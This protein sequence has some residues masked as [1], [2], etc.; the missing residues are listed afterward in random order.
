MLLQ[1]FVNSAKLHTRFH[2]LPSVPMHLSTAEQCRI[3]DRSTI[4]ARHLFADRG[5][6]YA[7]QQ[8][9]MSQA[10][11]ASDTVIFAS[12]QSHMTSSLVLWALAIISP[13]HAHQCCCISACPPLPTNALQISWVKTQL[14]LSK[15]S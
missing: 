12:C 6:A 5:D 10:P 2:P 9:R 11:S 13:K 4:M 7:D 14:H 8:V 3:R 15:H 1:A